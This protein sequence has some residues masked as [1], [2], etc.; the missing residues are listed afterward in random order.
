MSSNDFF[1]IIGEA[2]L[3]PPD[4]KRL[5]SVLENAKAAHKSL[6]LESLI[7]QADPLPIEKLVLALAV[8][9][10]HGLVQRVLRVESPIGGG[11][12]DFK[13]TAEIPDEMHDPRTDQTLRVR[14][15]NIHVVYKF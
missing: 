6:T 3:D 5:A 7:Q 4:R 10:R 9:V 14:P 1:T 13:S 11:I 12:G 15:E 2:P 8:L